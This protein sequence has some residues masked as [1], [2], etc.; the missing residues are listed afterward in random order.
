MNTQISA[1][2]FD[3]RRRSGTLIPLEV[4]VLEAGLE[5]AAA[6]RTEFHGFRLAKHIRD[7]A[8]AKRLTAH[9]TLYRSL[10]R[11]EKAGLLGSHWED[12]QIA[13]DE[14]RPLRRLYRVT[15]AGEAALA[16][17]KEAEL[18]AARPKDRRVEA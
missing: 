8:G 13:A 5:L 9:G 17:A 6:G 11:L 1:Y 7:D 15:P 3:M 14:G 10:S 4:A 18:A 16:K 12:P 2:S